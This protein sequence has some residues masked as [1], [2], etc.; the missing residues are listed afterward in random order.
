MPLLPASLIK[1]L[2]VEFASLIGSRTARSTPRSARWAVIAAGFPN[3]V[4]FAALVRRTPGQS[5]V[6][7]P[8]HPSG[9]RALNRADRWS[10]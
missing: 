2:W 1:P 4:V 8:Y 7:G 10:L 3:R 5:G 6:F 9:G